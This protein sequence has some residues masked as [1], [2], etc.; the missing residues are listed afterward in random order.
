M[1]RF[2]ISNLS[3]LSKIIREYDLYQF[4]MLDRLEKKAC[5]LEFPL[6]FH[7]LFHPHPIHTGVYN[8]V[9]DLS[10]IKYNDGIEEYYYNWRITNITH[11][12]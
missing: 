1:K 8:V 12:L 9:M 10:G 4:E 11:N 2:H 3:G 7:L 5:E 6:S